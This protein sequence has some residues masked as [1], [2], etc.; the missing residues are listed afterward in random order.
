MIR[1]ILWRS[2]LVGLAVL[3]FGANG[4][5][6]QQS[7]EPPE[8][9]LT[10]LPVDRATVLEDTRELRERAARLRQRLETATEPSAAPRRRP[11]FTGTGLRHVPD[12]GPAPETKEQLQAGARGRTEAP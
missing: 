3:V 4:P 8:Q 10:P 9:L 7:P 1:S 6:A 12:R 5:V 11:A 2:A